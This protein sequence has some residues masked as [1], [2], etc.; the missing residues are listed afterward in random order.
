MLWFPTTLKLSV[1]EFMNFSFIAYIWIDSCIDRTIKF[2][3]REDWTLFVS[4]M[5][6]TNIGNKVGAEVKK[7]DAG[8]WRDLTAYWILGLC[9]NFGYVVMLCAAHDIIGRLHPIGVSPPEIIRIN[10]KIQIFLINWSFRK[11]HQPIITPTEVV[12]LCQLALFYWPTF[13]H[14]SLSNRW[15]RFCRFV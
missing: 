12:K 13:F 1:K 5:K 9:N 2:P 15:A 10:T 3:I 8:R 6:W 7:K 11:S 14:H 4:K